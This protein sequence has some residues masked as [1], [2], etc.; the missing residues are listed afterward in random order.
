VLAAHRLRQSWPE[1]PPSKWS[2]WCWRTFCSPLFWKGILRRRSQARLDRNPIGWLHQRTATARVS[3][4]I[5]CVAA[6]F[7]SSA[8]VSSGRASV[9]FAFE[10]GLAL[11]MVFAGAASFRRERQ[12][13]VMELL[14]VAPLDLADIVDN[15]LRAVRGQFAPAVAMLVL[16]SVSLSLIIG[17]AETGIIAHALLVLS[18]WA[19]L[20]A[21]G[22]YFSFQAPRFLTAWLLGIAVGLAA[23]FFASRLLLQQAETSFGLVALL[24]LLMG[25]FVMKLLRNGLQRGNLALQ[26][27]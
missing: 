13:G 27:A 10:V 4:W 14:L 6:V 18:S 3:K 20:P 7:T 21:L 5:W 25:G 22:L 9:F 15:R 24:Q 8:M 2:R 19:L 16:P 1:A 12:L 17:E 23:P 26:L 11:A